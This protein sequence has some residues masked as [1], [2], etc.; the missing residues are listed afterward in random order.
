MHVGIQSRA[1][2]AVAWV[3]RM[4]HKTDDAIL[5]QGRDARHPSL[6]FVRADADDGFGSHPHTVGVGIG[7]LYFQL[8]VREVGERGH[9]TA[10][11]HL[12]AYL[13]IYIGEDARPWCAYLCVLQ[14]AA[15]LG[16][17]FPEDFQFQI[18]HL[19]V[20]L[21]H[22]LLVG[23]LLAQLLQLQATCVVGQFG[24]THLVGS[25]RTKA[26]EVTLV[27]QLHLQAVQLHFAHTDVH[28]QVA[29]PRQVVQ[30]QLLQLVAFHLLLVQQF[31]VA[32]LGA[33]QVEPQDGGAGRHAVAL[34]AID[35]HDARRDGRG[36]Q[37]LGGRHYASHGGHTHF[38]GSALHGA[39]LQVGQ[40]HT[41]LCPTGQPHHSGKAHGHN[42]CAYKHLTAQALS[43]LFF[44][45]FSVH[46]RLLVFFVSCHSKV[47]IL[48]QT[49]K[50]L[51]YSGNPKMS[52]VRKWTLC[53]LLA[54][55]GG[56]Q[57]K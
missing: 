46:I 13:A 6:Q 44:G 23:V 42:A 11:R 52:T 24:L 15:C 41:T 27:A 29:Q 17:V 2:A 51:I 40:L 19:Q 43:S 28:L 3:E 47:Q 54:S 33:L 21:A 36:H 35:L 57:I 49:C 14:C 34:F 30:P 39:R 45:Y 10:L 38:D 1:Q 31:A 16:Q 37:L 26:V 22:L 7:H 4:H 55:T 18:L 20:G 8:E 32:G 48:C 50:W 5:R 53:P 25:A 9:L 12:C 56:Q